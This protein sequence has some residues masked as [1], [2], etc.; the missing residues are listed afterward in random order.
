M[1]RVAFFLYVNTFESWFEKVLGISKD[2]YIESYRN[3]WVWNYVLGLQANEI[4][5]WIYIPSLK[6]EGLYETKE[7][8]KV[9]FLSM[10]HWYNF[11]SRVPFFKRFP[12][13]T[14]LQEGINSFAFRQSLELALV[15]DKISLV[16]VQEYWPARFDFLANQIDVPII[17]GDHGGSYSVA[18]KSIKRKTLPKACKIQ[19]Q[20]IEELN[21]VK[22][23]GGDALLL[24]NGID[25]NF[26]IP[27]DKKNFKSEKLIF[28]VARLTD[29]QK[30]TSDLIHA[31]TY[32]DEQWVLEIAGV[33]PDL[34]KLQALVKSLNLDKRVRFLGFISDK[35]KLRLKYQQCD[36][37]ALPSAWEAV[38]LA[39]LEAMSCGAA[40]V[41]SD[42]PPFRPLVSDGV[43]GVRVPVGNPESLANGI[44]KCYENKD[45]Y[46]VAA[47][48]TVVDSFS[49]QE[50][51][52]QLATVMKTYAH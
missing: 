21:R 3:D 17:A 30:K 2:D 15:K 31:M 1:K 51:L 39:M 20:T 44:T 45:C 5:I 26:F 50:N 28:T 40:V 16:Y 4:D 34:N 23:L 52:A 6:Y 41:A 18:I 49:N 43:N 19:C 38:A 32:L 25:T 13:G 14:F 42:I 8:I 37:F 22:T 10:S 27:G 33:G 29:P 36:V 12:V 46:G 7:Q 48:K 24:P 35:E 11:V 47:R 9:R